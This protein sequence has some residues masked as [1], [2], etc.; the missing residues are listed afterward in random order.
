[1][2]Y[3]S[4]RAAGQRVQQP[5]HDHDDPSLQL[6]TQSNPYEYS[7]QGTLCSD[8]VSYCIRFVSV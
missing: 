1:M 2:S 6:G 3:T 7:D 5:D 4:R 8:L